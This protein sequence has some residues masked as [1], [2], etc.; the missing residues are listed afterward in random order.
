MA[1]HEV[2][3]H[4]KNVDTTDNTCISSTGEI[5]M[6]Q[7]QDSCYNTNVSVPYWW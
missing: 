6:T 2:G 1:D 4:Q 5:S 7:D 3:A